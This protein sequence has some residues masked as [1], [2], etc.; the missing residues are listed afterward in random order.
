MLPVDIFSSR[1]FVAANLVTVVVYGALGGTFFLL[2]V[3]LQEVLHY[4]PLLAG[5]ALIPITVVMLLLSARAGHLAQQIGPRLPMTVG[6]LVVSAGLLLMRGIGAGGTYWA[7][8]FP[9]V[10]VFGLGLSFTVAPL[11]ATVLAAVDERHAGVA[12][13]VNNAVARA[14]SL[15]TVAVLP[16]LAG[17]TGN[18]YRHPAALS[19][20]FHK[21]CTITAG[22]CAVGAVIAWIGIRAPE[23]GA[24]VQ[25]VKLH[26]SFCPVDGPPFR[27]HPAA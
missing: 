25:P 27:R 19:A 21:A 15:L 18:S 1:V 9:A 13:G 20:G 10:V 24:P 8:V 14:A 23:Q 12:S 17:I 4:S 5:A 2:A 11:T 22:L 6:P 3:D 7:D 26:N 16:P